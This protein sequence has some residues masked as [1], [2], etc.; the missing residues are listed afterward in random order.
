MPREG[1]GTA[2]VD[3]G[4]TLAGGPSVREPRLQPVR[5]KEERPAAGGRGAGADA[6]DQPR[7]ATAHD[8]A[9]ALVDELWTGLVRGVRRS[10]SR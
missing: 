5:E 10:R 3:H 4:S 2:W 1:P 7:V 8:A 6:G 9:E